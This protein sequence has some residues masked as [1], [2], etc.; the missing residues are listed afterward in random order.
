MPFGPSLDAAS[1]LN[2][3]AFAS[4]A[5]HPVPSTHWARSPYA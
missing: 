5:Y 3:R 2:L 1:E 4:I